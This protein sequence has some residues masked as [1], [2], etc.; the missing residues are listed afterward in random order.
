MASFPFTNVTDL[1]LNS[2]LQSHHVDDS[3]PISDN[4]YESNISNL[5]NNTEEFEYTFDTN[6]SS[7]VKSLYYTQNQFFKNAQS[8]GKNDLNLLHLNIRSANKNLEQLNILLDNIDADSFVIGL[9]ETWFTDE[10]QSF[11]PES[12]PY[13]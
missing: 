8:A 1:D 10:P 5:L 4:Q 11:P 13:L 3:I 12:Q 6:D 7:H 2:L 9:T